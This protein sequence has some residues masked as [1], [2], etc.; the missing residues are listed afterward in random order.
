MGLV[1]R[2]I[3]NSKA[4]KIFWLLAPAALIEGMLPLRSASCAVDDSTS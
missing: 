3:K 2:Q 1:K 4:G